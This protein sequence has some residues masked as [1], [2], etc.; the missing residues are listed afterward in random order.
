M[1][2]TP[3]GEVNESACAAILWCPCAFL[4]TLEHVC[5]EQ[6]RVWGRIG[7]HT[8]LLLLQV[9]KPADTLVPPDS[10]YPPIHPSTHQKWVFWH[11]RKRMRGQVERESTDE[12]EIWGRA[13]LWLVD[14]LNEEIPEAS[15]LY[16]R[17][18]FQTRNKQSTWIC[19]LLDWKVC[20]FSVISI[21][22]IKW[23][24]CDAADCLQQSRAEVKRSD[25]ATKALLSLALSHMKGCFIF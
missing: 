5:G 12:V 7:C 6:T 20:L 1:Y 22:D 2:A 16:P 10:W 23:L 4:R 13:G 24:L 18:N 17:L 3:A 8:Q 15:S 11:M 14:H 21:A 9:Y 25:V 19:L